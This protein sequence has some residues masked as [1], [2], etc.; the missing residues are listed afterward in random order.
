MNPAYGNNTAFSSYLVARSRRAAEEKKRKKMAA[1]LAVE[2]K[3][4]ILEWR[5]NI[6]PGKSFFL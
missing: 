5:K 3:E 1:K 6:N 2:K 4:A